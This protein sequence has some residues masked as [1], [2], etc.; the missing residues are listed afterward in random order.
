[1]AEQLVTFSEDD[2]LAA[3]DVVSRRSAESSGRHIEWVRRRLRDAIDFLQVHGPDHPDHKA[4]VS[5]AM[6]VLELA[7][8]MGGEPSSTRMQ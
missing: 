1:M 8:Q 7:A 6:P 2:I 3:I 5:I 4:H